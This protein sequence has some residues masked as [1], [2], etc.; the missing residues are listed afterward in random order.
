MAAPTEARDVQVMCEITTNHVSMGGWGST[1][2]PE[3]CGTACERRTYLLTAPSIAALNPCVWLGMQPASTGLPTCG[4]R[5]K[6]K[7]LNSP[8][9]AS[10]R[11]PSSPVAGGGVG[12]R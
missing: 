6:P 4:C 11:V 12:A 9:K 5:K 7:I 2:A 3:G 1:D 10:S 8:L